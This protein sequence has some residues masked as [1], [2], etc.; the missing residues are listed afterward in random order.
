MPSKGAATGKKS[1]KKPEV[2]TVEGNTP[3]S[4]DNGNAGGAGQSPQAPPSQGDYERA[5]ELTPIDGDV[6]VE[7]GTVAGTY[8]VVAT[9]GLPGGCAE[10][11][12][13]EIHQAGAM[14]DI[15]VYILV[16][17]EPRPCTMIYKTYPIRIG[18]GDTLV[19]GTTYTVDL[20]GHTVT[21]TA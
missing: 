18:L 8:V 3:Q 4:P 12:G 20:N 13:Y 6:T 2:R 16:P 1:P 9:G 5:R 21:F 7:P 10:P 14:I 15:D 19:A 11:G 17:A